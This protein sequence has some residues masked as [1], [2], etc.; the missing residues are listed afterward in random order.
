KTNVTLLKVG[1]L[2]IDNYLHRFLKE[3]IKF[4]FYLWN[5]IVYILRCIF[6]QFLSTG[7]EINLEILK[8]EK[9]PVEFIKL[10]TVLAKIGVGAIIELRTCR[11][12]MET[13][14]EKK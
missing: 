7:V 11:K 10:H 6:C 13:C 2:V 12:R 8:A 1:M 14:R 4:P 3:E 9:L 5:F